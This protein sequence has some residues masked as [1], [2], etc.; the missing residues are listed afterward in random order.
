MLRINN[1]L[2]MRSF[3]SPAIMYEKYIPEVP[4]TK[5]MHLDLSKWNDWLYEDISF[6][7]V[8]IL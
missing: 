1:K 5:S 4:M 8:L 6:S 2:Y 7:F 3:I